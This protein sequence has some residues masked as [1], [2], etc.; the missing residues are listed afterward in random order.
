[1]VGVDAW[2]ILNPTTQESSYCCDKT[3]PLPKAGHYLLCLLPYH[4]FLNLPNKLNLPNIYKLIKWHWDNNKTNI[5][6]RLWIF[7]CLYERNYIY[8]V[9]ITVVFTLCWTQSRKLKI[10]VIYMTHVI[11]LN[12]VAKVT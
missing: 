6:F 4:T 1:M 7:I 11:F 5:Y 10:T 3:I 8:C 12:V 9:L 2:S